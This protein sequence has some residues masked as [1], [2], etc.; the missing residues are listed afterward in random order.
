MY[1]I[2][3]ADT[4]VTQV[5]IYNVGAR[6]DA[7]TAYQNASPGT[8]IS[9]ADINAFFVWIPEYKYYVVSGD[10][11]TSYERLINVNFLNRTDVSKEG[12]V[13]CVES[14][15]TKENPHLYSE[16]CTDSIYGTVQNNLSTYAHPAFSGREDG[17]WIG[18]FSNRNYSGYL[19]KAGQSSSYSVTISTSNERQLIKANNIYGFPQN[20]NASYN[21]TT[22]LYT[23]GFANLDSHPITS[24][25]WGAVAILT[26]SA[27][28]KTG[29]PM[30]YTDTNHDFTRVYNNPSSSSS[31][32]SSNY[33]TSSNS[34]NVTSTTTKN[35]YDLTDVTHTANGITYP[36]GY[37]G[38]GSSTTG[39]IYG[40]YDMAGGNY[41]KVMGMVMKED[42][43]A[44]YSMDRSFYTA[45][46]YIPYTG[47]I[48]D[49]NKAAYLEVFRLGDG[50]K[51]HVIRYSGNGMWQ[52]GNITFG[53]YGY[54]RRGGYTTS[55][56]L[57]TTEIN[58]TTSSV[59]DDTFTVLKY[60]PE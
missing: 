6:M 39:T 32:Y 58:Y 7:R 5:D 52:N 34:V 25:E 37:V 15:S 56:S 24:M 40:V 11:N 36:I 16:I 46:S 51:E 57:F 45:Y 60:Y 20:S 10:G 44:P 8:A 17:F 42:G 9:S 47:T 12:T 50:I 38:A 26:S 43:T 28:G 18:K 3:A 19:I 29:N 33:T 41:T 53:N 49:S 4:N 14:I 48:T 31:G 13:S 59:T 22:W 54:M 27:Y 23:N 1:K 21:S 30:Y 35:Y 55:G 2:N